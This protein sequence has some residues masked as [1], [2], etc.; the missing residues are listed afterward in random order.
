M[1]N[2]GSNINIFYTAVSMVMPV[3]GGSN[4]RKVV[5]VQLQVYE[6]VE[7]T[8]KNDWHEE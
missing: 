1:G 6:N 7:E 5:G 8:T 2:T 3:A 4:I